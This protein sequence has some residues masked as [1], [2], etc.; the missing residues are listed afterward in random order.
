MEKPMKTYH[1]E[2]ATKASE[3]ILATVS[4]NLTRFLTVKGRKH[5]KFFT[6]A[7]QQGIPEA[8]RFRM[9]HWPDCPDS[10][11]AKKRINPVVTDQLVVICLVATY[12]G[13]Q[14]RDIMFTDIPI[15]SL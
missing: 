13:K 2:A 10:P 14:P 3:E 4:R 1:S 9:L 7:E 11:H 8:K 6:W 5:S 15:N 12:M